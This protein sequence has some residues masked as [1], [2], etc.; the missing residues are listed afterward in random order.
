MSDA[1]AK[2]KPC[3]GLDDAERAYAT[4][5]C[6]CGPGALAAI[7]GMSLDEVRCHMGDFE[8]K[9]YTN[10]TLMFES[11]NRAGANWQTLSCRPLIWPKW[12]L[13]RIQWHGPWTRPGAPVR[14][15]YRHTH[16]VGSCVRADGNIGVFD[17]NA[18][19]NGSGWCS[20]KDWSEILVPWLLGQCEPAAD[21]RW[22]LTHSI[23]VECSA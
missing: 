4:W 22:S 13:V 6:N 19:S 18:M 21:G 11:L 3:F 9:G 17:I 16:W 23:E 20:I 7:M 10:P 2:A 5:G 8:R 1:G 12:G 14:A 15:A